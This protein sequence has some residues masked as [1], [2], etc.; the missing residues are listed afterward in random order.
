MGRGPVE[1]LPAERAIHRVGGLAFEAIAKVGIEGRSD[2][3]RR[4]AEDFLNR[5]ERHALGKHQRS[6]AVPE[7]VKFDSG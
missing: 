1:I 5:L 3:D 7:R 6:G 4:M 2:R